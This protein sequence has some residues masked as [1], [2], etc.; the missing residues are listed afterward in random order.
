[1]FCAR[2]VEEA[3]QSVKIVTQIISALNLSVPHGKKGKYSTRRG[4]VL[5]N[6]NIDAG[7][8]I[9]TYLVKN[10]IYRFINLTLNPGAHA[11]P[12][13]MPELLSHNKKERKF[14]QC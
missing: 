7:R 10:V 2:T 1:L 3:T 9:A 14:K 8:V 11:L 6:S 4:Y 13:L 12:R 5:P